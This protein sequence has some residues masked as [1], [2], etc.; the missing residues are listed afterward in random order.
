MSDPGFVGVKVKTCAHHGGPWEVELAIDRTKE[1]CRDDHPDI[2]VV[3]RQRRYLPQSRETL[4][5]L[6]FST[7]SVAL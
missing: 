6:R 3:G 5:F 7:T 2:H 4:D 1:H